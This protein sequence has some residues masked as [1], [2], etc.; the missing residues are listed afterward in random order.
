MLTLVEFELHPAAGIQIYSDAGSVFHGALMNIVG[1]ETASALHTMAIRPY[2]QCIYFDKARNK[3]IWR[4]GTLHDEAFEKIVAPLTKISAI[5]LK[6]KS[7][8]VALKNMTIKE[9]TSF[10]NIADTVF[11]QPQPVHKGELHFLTTTSCKHDNQYDI[12]PSFARLWNS[13]LL[14]WNTYAEHISLQQ[15]GLAYTLEKACRMT[16]YQLRSQSYSL[17][18]T[19]VFGYGGTMQFTCIGNAMTSRLIGMLLYLA[20]FSGIG[21]KTAL[22]MG[23][24]ETM[25]H[26]RKEER[27]HGR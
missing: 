7:A 11:A 9:Q 21:I 15:E 12:L 19:R 18:G 1:K 14:R 4:I 6:Q 16:Q 25:I 20:P 5:Y 2:S 23:G 3:P 17:E 27:V 22:G 26:Y 13:L 24:V 10:E 8:D